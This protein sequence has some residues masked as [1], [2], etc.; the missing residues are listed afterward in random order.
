MHTEFWLGELRE[1]DHLEVLVVDERLILRIIKW[2]FKKEG[3]EN[4]DWIHWAQDR[5]RHL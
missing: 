4:L 3:G 1:R 5:D 2:I